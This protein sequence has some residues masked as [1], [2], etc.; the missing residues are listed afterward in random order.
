[1]SIGYD[2]AVRHPERVECRPDRM[3][4]GDIRRRGML[5]GYDGSGRHPD[6]R[7]VIRIEWWLGDIR[8]SGMSAK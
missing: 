4:L 7:N 5:V 3:A 1:M 8:I 6:K 2:G